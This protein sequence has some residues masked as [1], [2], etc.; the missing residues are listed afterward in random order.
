[1]TSTA[2]A[3]QDSA[4]AGGLRIGAA[5]EALDRFAINTSVPGAASG[6]QAPL[7]VPSHESAEHSPCS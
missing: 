3:E 2:P 7:E 5:P 6:S 1:M 4:V